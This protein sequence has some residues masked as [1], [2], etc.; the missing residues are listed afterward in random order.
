MALALPSNPLVFTYPSNCLPL[1]VAMH[2]GF[3][4][5]IEITDINEFNQQLPS[6]TTLWLLVVWMEEKQK[7]FLVP[8]MDPISGSQGQQQNSRLMTHISR[9]GQMWWLW[10]AAVLAKC[11]LVPLSV[12]LIRCSTVCTPACQ[13]PCQECMP[14][15]LTPSTSCYR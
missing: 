14:I 10:M 13:G 1:L 11:H 6:S 5:E 8:V 15:S 3:N 2:V 9:F 12:G 7:T 4:N